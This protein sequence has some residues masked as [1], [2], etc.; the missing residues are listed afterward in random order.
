MSKTTTTI[1]EH[2]SHEP[3][4]SGCCGGEHGKDKKVPLDQKEKAVSPEYDKREPV[5]HAHG[6]SCGCGSG[7]ANK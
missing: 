6:D 1:D 4:K 5:Q 3:N 2:V 7:K